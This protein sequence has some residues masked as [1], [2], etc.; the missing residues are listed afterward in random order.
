MIEPK[1]LTSLS[2]QL[3]KDESSDFDALQTLAD[4]SLHILLPPSTVESGTWSSLP[5]TSL[6]RWFV[7]LLR[8]SEAYFWEYNIWRFENRCLS[9]S[10]GYKGCRSL[11]IDHHQDGAA[12]AI[13]HQFIFIDYS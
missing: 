10:C 6:L 13:D 2:L 1:P 12:Y 8:G 9:R 5:W 3:S 4:L 7:R 11:K